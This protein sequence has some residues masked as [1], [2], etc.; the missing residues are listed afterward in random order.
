MNSPSASI[1]RHNTPDRHRWLDNARM[2]AI[3]FVVY[4]H[5]PNLLELSG[6][7]SGAQAEEIIN[8]VIYNGMVPFFLITAGYLAA[9]K[10]TWGY[11][12]KRFLRLL[13][14]FFLWNAI[15]YCYAQHDLFAVLHIS[16]LSLMGMRSL[17]SSEIVLF[18]HAAI[19]PFIMPSW[20]LRDLLFLTLLTPIFLQAKR[21]LPYAL[22]ILFI[23]PGLE[24]FNFVGNIL[25]PRTIAFYL[26]GLLLARFPIEE[27]YA[28]LGAKRAPFF[29]ITALLGAGIGILGCIKQDYPSV[30]PFAAQLFG[31]AMLAH[32]GI[33]IE[34]HLPKLSRFFASCTPAIFLI[35]MLHLPIL[36]ML[37][38][39]L[40]PYITHSWAGLL[41]PIPVC[42]AIILLYFAMERLTPFLLPYLAYAKRRKA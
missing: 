7:F 29:A 34:K 5:W 24:S 1:T 23:T 35:F 9:G 3:L 27:V 38:P 26:L 31:A 4:R 16:P 21:I 13:I 11:C 41:L 28:H 25:S 17:F 32:G 42:A 30:S 12:F 2:L 22:L 33:L 36:E 40:P 14:P 19:H 6:R 20:Y 15:C 39:L 18:P 8:A 10:A 37:H